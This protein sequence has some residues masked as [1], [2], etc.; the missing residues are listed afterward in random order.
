[1]F[2]RPCSSRATFWKDVENVE[3]SFDCSSVKVNGGVATT[4]LEEEEALDFLGA[5]PF[6]GMVVMTM[7]ITEYRN[8]ERRC[9]WEQR[10]FSALEYSFFR[11]NACLFQQIYHRF[12]FM[13]WYSQSTM[14]RCIPFDNWDLA[15]GREQTQDILVVDE[16]QRTGFEF[17]LTESTYVDTNLLSMVSTWNHSPMCQRKVMHVISRDFR[18]RCEPHDIPIRSLL[19]GWSAG[20]TLLIFLPSTTC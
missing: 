11:E 13:S 12:P 8:L 1:M 15:N 9:H 2:F 7:Q 5:A 19:V 18:L 17:Y 20:N 10:L 6:L 14:K 16:K 3:S 4:L